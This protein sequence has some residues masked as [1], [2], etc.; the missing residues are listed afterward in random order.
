M[1]GVSVIIPAFNAANYLRAAID[2]VLA[3]DW[4]GLDVLVVDN[5]SSDGTAAIAASYGAPVRCLQSKPP[6][7]PATTNTGI[8]HAGTDWL[9]F[10]DA[11]DLWTPG[12]LQRQ[13]REFEDHPELDA[14]FGHAVNFSG[15]EPRPGDCISEEMPAP[16][17]GTLLI[18]HEAFERV[19]YFDESFTIGSIMDWYLRARESG[20]CMRILPEVFLYRRVHGDNLG[21]RHKDRQG[22]YVHI[23]K[24]ALDRR[25]KAE[26]SAGQ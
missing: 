16:L 25:R 18:R 8:R 15:A 20:L 23:L 4:P 6:G 21:L 26:G 3:Q 5:D 10:L 24:A 22:D 1:K 14:V 17:P 7:Q 12:K 13:F 19:G 11:D 2:S 9:A